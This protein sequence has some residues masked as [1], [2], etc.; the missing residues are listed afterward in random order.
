MVSGTARRRLRAPE[1]GRRPLKAGK[2]VF[3]NR[4][5][6][7]FMIVL[8]T[9]L[10]GGSLLLFGV[11]L[12]IGPFTMIRFAASEAQ[13]LIWDGCLSLLFFIQHSGMMRASFRNRISSAIPSDYHPATYSI[14]SGIVLIVVV[15][16]WQTSQT[17]LFQIQGPLRVLPRVISL[18]AIVGFVWGVRALRTFDPFGRIPIVVRL[19][20]KQ[21]GPPSFDLGGPYLWV[22]HPLYFFTL[23]LIWV[24]PVMSSDR[25]LF[26]VLWTFWVVIGSYLEEKDLVAEFGE[27]Y[28]RYQKTV[29]MLLPWRGPVGR[30]PRI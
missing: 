2:E 9:V 29:P 3:V 30:G 16:L 18:F 13:T 23:V 15:L 20:D 7:H 22:R 14:L 1:A 12:I 25:L 24:A 21:L 26:N 17:V 8:S 10:G 5:A 11:F 28:R 4:F 6:A 19:R 27:R